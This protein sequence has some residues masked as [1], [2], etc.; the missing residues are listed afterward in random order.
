MSKVKFM[1]IKFLVWFLLSPVFFSF[2]LC[3][4]WHISVS[5]N[6]FVVDDIW[7]SVDKFLVN[8]KWKHSCTHYSFSICLHYEWERHKKQFILMEG[9]KVSSFA[10]FFDRCKSDWVD[11]IV[12]VSFRKGVNVCHCKI[13]DATRFLWLTQCHS[14]IEYTTTFHG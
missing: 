13:K 1:A 8:S 11:G 14:E 6:I 2:Y 9:V 5:D 7:R 3:A 12:L 10:F 4:H